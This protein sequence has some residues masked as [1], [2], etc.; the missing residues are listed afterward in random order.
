MKEPLIVYDENLLNVVVTGAYSKGGIVSNNTDILTFTFAC[1]SFKQGKN[2]FEISLSFENNNMINLY[3]SKECDTIG[4]VQEYFNFF[5]TMYYILL[6][7]LFGFVITVLYYY[8]KRNDISGLDIYN[9]IKS[10]AIII[11]YFIRDKLN[12]VK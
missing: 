1:T 4:E 6:M 8:F 10:K 3:F 9:S 11:Y 12:R 7:I 5:Y 2:D